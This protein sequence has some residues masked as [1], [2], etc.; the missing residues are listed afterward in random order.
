MGCDILNIIHFIMLSVKCWIE[1]PEIVT[2]SVFLLFYVRTDFCFLCCCWS[3]QMPSSGHYASY[4]IS[5]VGCSS[6]GYPPK[7]NSTWSTH[8]HRRSRSLSLSPPPPLSLSLYCSLCLT[9]RHTNTTK[10]WK[11]SCRLQWCVVFCAAQLGIQDLS[12]PDYGESVELQ[13]G[14]VPVFW[15]CGVTAIEAILSSSE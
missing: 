13:A 3:F 6:E 11:C 9:D 12:K 1:F 14:D 2:F 5:I 7:P 8:T 4:S 10:T 15:A